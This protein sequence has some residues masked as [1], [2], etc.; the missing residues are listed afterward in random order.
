MGKRMS[1]DRRGFG[2]GMMGHFLKA[3][4]VDRNISA[5]TQSP[6]SELISEGGRVIGIRATRDG[7]DFFIRTR[8]GVLLAVGGYDWHPD[9]PRHFEGLPEW[10]S[11]CQPNVEGDN[12][13]LGGEVGAAL[14]GVPSHN[15]G[16]FFGYQ[17]PGEEHE[18]RPLFRASWEGGYPHAIWVNRKGERF[19]DESFYRDYLPRLHAW[20]G[21][22]Q[23]HP[24]YPPYLIFDQDYRDRY[25]LG[26]FMPGQD[27]PEALVAQADTPEALAEKLGIDANGLQATLRHFNSFAG[28]DTDPDFGRGTYPWAR[29]MIGD[30]ARPN[31]NMGPVER[32]PFYGLALRPV[33]AG[34]NAVGLRT[35]ANGQVLHVRGHAI[36]GLYAAGNSAAPLDT[37][38]GY[39]SGLSNLRGLTWGYIAGRHALEAP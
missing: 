38:A 32:A 3:A 15:L 33:G 25:P 36:G 12:V 23:T 28:G 8:K 2:P 13:V 39:Q 26:S 21:I 37:G 24:N 16:M 27:L 20:D 31:P 6:A 30:R 4:L 1:E 35:D 29:M 10:N 18:G 5:F 19:A 17:V 34:I 9:F 7:N 22:T 14:A 11:M